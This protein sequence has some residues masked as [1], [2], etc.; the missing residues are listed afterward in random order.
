MPQLKAY[1]WIPD[2]IK[3][4]LDVINSICFT[5]PRCYASS[6]WISGL[7]RKRT[8]LFFFLEVSFYEIACLQRSCME[9]KAEWIITGQMSV[10]VLLM[11]LRASVLSFL[12]STPVPTQLS[13]YE[14][15]EHWILS[16]PISHFC[17]L[18]FHIVALA[19]RDPRWKVNYLRILK[20]LARKLKNF[21][22]ELLV[23]IHKAC[24]VLFNCSLSNLVWLGY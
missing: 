22:K 10:L 6:D 14:Q 19:C 15:L 17:L 20:T 18:R 16:I 12:L 8:A 4:L 2:D 9:R 13:E 21:D 11:E 23:Y 5:V 7:V 1:I 3:L 24:E